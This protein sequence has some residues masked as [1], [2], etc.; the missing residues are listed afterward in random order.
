MI[1][2]FRQKLPH[3]FLVKSFSLLW[4]VSVMLWRNTLN[5][6]FLFTYEGL[7]VLF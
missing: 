5:K 4:A 2:S 3:K 6:H 7:Q 1:H